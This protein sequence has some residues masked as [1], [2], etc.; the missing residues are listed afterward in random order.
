MPNNGFYFDMVG[1]E[2]LHLE[3]EPPPL[4]EMEQRYAKPIDPKTLD[5]LAAK[6]QRL[7]PTGKALVFG[8]WFDFGPPAVGNSTDWLCL[9]A[10]EPDYVGRLF[11]LKTAADLANLERL[12]GAMGDTIDVFGI[13]GYDFGTQRSETFN[14]EIFERFHLPYYTAINQWVHTHTPWKTWKHCCGSI[15]RFLPLFVR[16]GLDCL[17]PMQTSAVGMDPRGLKQ[18]FGRDLTFWGGGVD[19]QRVLPFGKPEEVYAHVKERLE[20]FAPGGGFVFNTVHNIQGTVPAE[21]IEA[22]FR[23]VRDHGRYGRT[24]DGT[25]DPSC[26]N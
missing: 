19:T 20:I 8:A 18:R 10:S 11:E 3:F 6:A 13:D 15:A 9:L 14:P 22:M 1:D 2:S 24:G 25:R 23:A 7:R 21:N 12:W 4:A 5:F 17:N 16:S 26:S